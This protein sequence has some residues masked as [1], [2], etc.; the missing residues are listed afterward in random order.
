MPVQTAG[1]TTPL[2]ESRFRQ[3]LQNKFKFHRV[4]FTTFGAQTEAAILVEIEETA[5]S[6]PKLLQRFNLA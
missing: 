2:D 1:N 6:K 5:K 4:D 3:D